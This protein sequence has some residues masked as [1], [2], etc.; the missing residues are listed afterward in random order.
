[1]GEVPTETWN[2]A[3]YHHLCH[4]WG[5]SLRTGSHMGT[6]CSLM[7]VFR[8][9]Y[10]YGD[11]TVPP[12]IST[13]DCSDVSYKANRKNS[14]TLPARSS[15]YIFM[16]EFVPAACVYR[17]E[18]VCLMQSLK[19]AETTSS[20]LS[21][22]FLIFLEIA[23]V[24]R[25]MKDACVQVAAKK[26][27]RRRGDCPGMLQVISLSK[28]TEIR[29]DDIQEY[30]SSFN[31]FRNQSPD[32]PGM[33]QIYRKNIL[34]PHSSSSKCK[35]Q[36]LGNSRDNL[37]FC[38]N[39]LT[40][41]VGWPRNAW[42]FEWSIIKARPGNPQLRA[43]WRGLRSL[44]MHFLHSLGK[45]LGGR[46]MLVPVPEQLTKSQEEEMPVTIMPVFQTIG[47]DWGKC[48]NVCFQ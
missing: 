15:F 28:G 26:P 6:H 22:H 35:R 4:S 24:S 47:S 21:K 33:L 32:V 1:M 17:G 34:Y 13:A 46:P 31:I 25:R 38:T 41:L 44:R 5:F 7:T 12:P 18:H 23:Y 16:Q 42:A 9:T 29:G 2:T 30:Y 48:L 45:C 19:N 40:P 3:N 11:L 36:Y 39:L 27:S 37:L 20:S 8:L 10:H 14:F 43:F